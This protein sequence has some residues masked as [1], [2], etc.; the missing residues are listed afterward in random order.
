MESLRL[1]PVERA[2]VPIMT[3]LNRQG[4]T[5]DYLREETVPAVYYRPGD[6]SMTP[7]QVKELQ[8]ALNA[9]AG[10]YAWHHK[11][12]VLPPGSKTMPQKETS[13]A[14][15]FDNIVM[16]QTAMAFDVKPMELGIMP[17]VST[18]AG[19]FATREMAAATRSMTQ[20]A[21]LQPTLQFIADIFNRVLQDICGQRDMQFQFQGMSEVQDQAAT[22]DL[23]VKQVQ[24]GIRSLDEARD[25][26]EL[27]PWGE[28]LTSSP[29]VFTAQ[30]VVP[31]GALIQSGPD[32]KTT[33]SAPGGG[34]KDGT[35]GAH[36][37]ARGAITGAPDTR[38]L[39]PGTV[40]ERQRAPRRQARAR[41]L[42]GRRVTRALRGQAGRRQGGHCGP[43]RRAG[44]TG[45]PRPASGQ[46]PAHHHLGSKAHPRTCPGGDRRRPHQGDDRG[47]GGGPRQDGRPRCHGVR[48][49]R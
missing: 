18:L 41:A 10:D 12:I 22:T 26:L 17:T 28:G 40:A 42:H 2:L 47:T 20:R 5:L 11:I 21:S 48:L 38:A 13:L 6:A 37:A 15:A 29:V 46:G 43:C 7:N 1:P 49:G 14:D 8:L 25:I 44:G 23:L 33:T 30:G 32:G 9:V 39:P 3:G 36:E 27:P 45:G 19:S 35:T 31:F 4:W 16:T 34:G 24:S